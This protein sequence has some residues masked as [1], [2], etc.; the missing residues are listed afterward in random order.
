MFG[1]ERV[2]KAASF[3]GILN[4]AVQDCMK[5]N[6]RLSKLTEK[7]VFAYKLQEIQQLMEVEQFLI[8]NKTRCTNKVELNVHNV[9]ST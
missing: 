1:C 2:M 8:A 9:R 7:N 3:L 6:E 5:D 4:L